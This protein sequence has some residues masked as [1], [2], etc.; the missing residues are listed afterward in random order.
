[1]TKRDEIQKEASDLIIKDKD[2]ILF[3]SIRLGK[4]RIAINA[5][6]DKDK[7]ILIIYPNH[8][9]RKSWEDEFVKC[10][11]DYSNV[12]FIV[13]NSIKKH[14]NK[15]YDYIIIDEPQLLSKNQI[16]S[17]KT[18]KFNKRVALS[19]TLKDS[20]IKKLKD[21]LGLQV[22]YKYTISE[23]IKDKI[24]KDYKINIHIKDLNDK[25]RNVKY[26]KYGKNF[27][28]T[29]KNVYNEYSKSMNYFSSNYEESKNFKYELGFKKYMSLRTNFLYDSL[30]LYNLAQ[31]LIKKYKD[32]KVL[33]YTL[34][35]DI[36]DKLSSNSYHT[37]NKLKYVL[38]D[39][40]EAKN[41]H[42][43]VVN[44]VQTGVTIKDLNRVIFHTYESNTELFYQKLGRSLLYEYEDQVANIHICCLKDTQ[45][46]V[47]VNNAC[48]AL[49]Q[50]KINYI[51]NNKVYT[52][53]EWLKNKYNNNLY[54]YNDNYCYLTD[55][56]QSKYSNYKFI[57]NPN[58]SYILD[59][60]KLVK[61]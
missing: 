55:E 21:E 2:L 11:V 61:I 6:T 12:T 13:K 14:E 5:I 45:M 36:A 60:D 16:N 32:N 10:G 3:I 47:W 7:N 43:S 37:G 35:K 24:V 52:K 33:I 40:K 42:L 41:G 20:T 25:S 56:V 59:S 34:R 29:E 49:E 22:K 50:D 58:K 39:F 18:I 27:I 8:S 57:D 38:E 19:G 15:D 53:I 48:K 4:T 9:V 51:Y 54:L 1:M 28:D 30:T 46:E 17:L 31:D 44:C 26:K 23:A